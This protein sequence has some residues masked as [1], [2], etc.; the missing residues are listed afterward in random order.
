MR[1]RISRVVRAGTC[2][3]VRARACVCV[4]ERERAC[5]S[6]AWCESVCVFVFVCVCVVLFSSFLFVI[7]QLEMKRQEKG[8]APCAVACVGWRGL[9]A[10]MR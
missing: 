7:K 9:H 5:V 1:S 4:C 2:V 10:S 8:A 3:C 6:V